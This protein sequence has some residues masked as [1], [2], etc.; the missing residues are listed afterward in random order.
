MHHLKAALAAALTLAAPL[1]AAPPSTE[2]RIQDAIAAGH[3]A[4]NARRSTEGSGS[5]E[6]SLD[7]IAFET[8]RRCR[9]FLASGTTQS[10]A[11]YFAATMP[12]RELAAIQVAC[13][14]YRKGSEDG[15][16]TAAR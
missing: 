9:V 11:D 6:R 15:P 10:A 3:R 5:G 2:T 14:I 8:A 16:V 1:A 12:R 4:A 13:L 7:D